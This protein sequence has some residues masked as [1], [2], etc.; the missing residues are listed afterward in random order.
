MR[1]RYIIGLIVLCLFAG[2][3]PLAAQEARGTLLGRVTDPTGAVIVGAKVDAVNTA[4]GVHFPSTTNGDGEYIVPFLLPGPY[5]LTAEMAGF[6]TYSRTGMTVRESDRITVDIVMDV[7]AANEKVTVTGEAP[8]VDTSTAS[9]GQVVESRTILELPTKDSMVLVLATMVPGVTFTPQ[10]TAYIRPFDTGSPS[11]LS[12]NG[13]RQLNNEF[14]LDGSNNTQG[15]QVAYS[16]PQAVVDEFKV[17]TAT[18]DASFG[19]MPGAAV[20]MTLKTGTNDLHGQINYFMQNPALN[21]NNYFRLAAGKPDMRIHRMSSSLTG[22]V[23]I[24]KVYNGRN[25]TFFTAAFEWIY[26]FDPSPWVVES[27]PTAAERAG[28][29]SSLL[30]VGSN[31][32]IYDP[33]S[34]TAAANGQFSRTPLPNNIIPASQINPVAANIAKL[35][36]MP[37]QQ[38]TADNTNNYTMGKNAQDT[39]GNELFRIDHNV[40]EK[41]RFYVR[42]N[43][44]SL[45]RPENVRQNK[46]DGD[47]FYRFNRGGSFDNVYL[48]SPR[49]FMDTRFTVTRFYTGYTPYQEG[50]DLSSLG[51]SSTY[52]NDIKALDPRALIFPYIN[53]AGQSTLGGVNTYNEQWYN[54]YDAAVNFTNLVGRHTLH[55]GLGYRIYQLNQFDMSQSSGNLVANSTYTNGPFNNSATAPIGQGMASFLYGILAPTSSFPISPTNLAEEDRYWAMYIQDDYKLSHK[56]TLSLGLRYELPSPLTERYNRSVE[57][58]NATGASTIA[59][60]AAAN[61]A[62]SPVPQLSPSQFKALGGL[63]FA[64]VG[65]N[66]RNLW[67]TDKKEFMPRIGLAYNVNS[68]TVIRAGYGIYYQ[69]LGIVNVAGSGAG[70]GGGGVLNQ[71]GFGSTSSFVGTTNNG[72][73]YIANLTNPFPNGFVAPTGSSAGYN[74][75]LG[76]TVSFYDKNLRNPYMQRW[77]FAVQRELP[78]TSLVELSYVGNRSTRLLVTQDM[79]PTPRQYMSTLPTRDQATINLLGSQVANPFYPLL[80]ATNLS[81]STI[82]LS[83]LLRPYPQFSDVTALENA[84]FSWYHAFQARVE[85]RFSNGLSAQYSFTWSKWM[86]ATSYLNPTD[87]LPEKV[88]SDLDRPMRHVLAWIYEL[89]FG[90]G[91][92]FLG[93]ANKAEAKVIGGWQVQT[94]FT[95][96]TGQALGFGDALL[97]PGETMANVVLPASQRSVGEWFNVSAFNRV[98][99]QQLASNIIT[100]SSAFSGV[101][102]PDVNNWDISLIKNTAI[103][104]RVKAQFSTLFINGLNHPQFTAPN[105]TPTSS[106]FGQLTG[107]Y[108]WNRLI[109]FGLKVQF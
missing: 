68:K 33:F 60:Q 87:T 19:F 83:Q 6:K 61:Y 69:P 21:A 8:L 78:L 97:N 51:F 39:Y 41:E 10:T 109:E 52:V 74:T 37:N 101:R 17:Q 54:T 53:V 77:Q 62:A 2:A 84:G 88:I 90:P 27:V 95:H 13:V 46:T 103:S 28:N 96:Q 100:M 16:P 5:S 75:F 38:G 32:Q 3:L 89:P 67:N 43:L 93:S 31:Y 4:T 22:P 79:D 9:M 49:F 12:V 70:G 73:S 7:G 105:T 80:P 40:S 25:K 14:M 18:F 71:A 50:W 108:N 24:P 72:Q 55:Y 91:K 82:A 76:Q 85:K 30:N 99:S 98:S 1:S 20:N 59:A 42:G 44:T 57:G 64:G 86:Q 104:E 65:G 94:V 58:F 26:S 81:G 34:T 45:E 15:G 35:W 102:A 66:S 11:S 23:D 29:F 47:N 107:A 56:M 48:F 106:A 92:P 36:D 63:T